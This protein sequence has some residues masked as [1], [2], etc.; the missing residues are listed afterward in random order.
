MNSFLPRLLRHALAPLRQPALSDQTLDRLS[1][2]VS[3]SEKKHGGQIRVC[4]ESR[5]PT[6][7]LRRP[8]DMKRIVRQRAV[9]QFGKLR[10]WDTEQNNGV[11]IYLQ[12]AERRIE[13][14][15]DRAIQR[16]VGSKP[17][18]S[19]VAAMVEPL[20]RGNCEGALMLAIGEVSNVLAAH[21]PRTGTESGANELP[22]HLTV[23]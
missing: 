20:R 2:A 4:V 21:F 9:S 1:Q 13:I 19:I 18:E 22:D 16:K 6:S 7:Y 11:L 15:A 12:L 14:V 3:T 5:L 8:H 23:N 10:V 17:W